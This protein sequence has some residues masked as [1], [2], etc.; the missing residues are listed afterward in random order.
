[1]LLVKGVPQA[2][3]EVQPTYFDNADGKTY[4]DDYCDVIPRDPCNHA[5]IFCLD[6][7]PR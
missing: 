3:M 2:Y 6:S 4:D 1:M 7:N 5:F